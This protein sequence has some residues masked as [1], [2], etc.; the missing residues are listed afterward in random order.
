[1]IN[2]IISNRNQIYPRLQLD[3][4]FQDLITS[5]M[6]FCRS[7]DINESLTRITSFFPRDKGIVV[8]FSVRTAF[9]LLL[10]S[11]KF[12]S[13]S[14]VLMSAINIQNMV[15]I[16]KLNGLIPVPV[17]ISLKGCEPSL[18]L[19]EKLV[20]KKTKILLIAHLFGTIIDLQPYVEFCQK[21]NLILIEDCAQ[22]FAGRKYYG[23]PQADVSFFSFGAIKSS[24]AL[25]G[26]VAVFKDRKQAEKIEYLQQHYPQKSELWFFVRV[27]KFILLKILSIPRIYYLLLQILQIFKKDLDSTINATTRGFSQG[28]LLTKLRYQPPRHLIWFLAYR[29]SKCE[30]FSARIKTAENFLAIIKTNIKNMKIP[31]ID[32]NYHSYWLFPILVAKPESLMVKLRSHNFD[33]TR[34]TTSLTVPE[35]A[36]NHSSHLQIEN[37]Q[38]LMKHVLFL[39]VSHQV[40][41]TELER[42]ANV[43]A[44]EL[45]T[46]DTNF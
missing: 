12:P 41:S 28:N 14:E 32:A 36:A 15:E 9:D 4:S 33:V 17:D 22:A 5:I 18:E 25:G 30:N 34:G 1:M 31:G 42:L 16:I 38:Y 13:D 29:L 26:G 10:Q 46:D 8:T 43:L 7:L 19:L 11:L 39:P 44:R 45:N 23:H 20:S 24:T 3:I 27:G 2:S 21:Y 37:A 35:A 6:S 40:P